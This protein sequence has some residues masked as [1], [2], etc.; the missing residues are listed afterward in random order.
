MAN[1]IE[2]FALK[3]LRRVYSKSFDGGLPVLQYEKDVDK[4]SD[5]IYG[6]LSQGKS[7]MIA[8]FGSTELSALVNYLGVN[9][10]RHSA[11]AYVMGRQPEWWWNTNIMQQMQRWS[12]FFPPTPENMQRFGDMMMRDIRELDL[13]GC[14]VANEA[15]LADRLASV[16]KVHLRLLEPFWGAR[17]WSRWLCGKRVVVVHPFAEAIR[18]QY[19]QRR[20]LLFKNEDVLPEFASLRVVKAVQ[21]LGGERKGFKDWFEALDHMKAEIASEDYDV[22]LIGCGAYGFPLAAEVKRQG[23]QAIHLGGALQLLFGIKGRRWENPNYGV[24]EWGIPYGSYCELMNEHWVRPGDSGRPKNAQLVE[25]AC[26][27]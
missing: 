5:M 2:I 3:A 19:E 23:R 18:L 15:W 8:R 20:E 22:C 21:S 4:A 7:C 27:W 9:A 25:G 6:L 13:L 14:W 17:P 16:Q 26:Y 1:K 12:G 24:R 10:K 11:L